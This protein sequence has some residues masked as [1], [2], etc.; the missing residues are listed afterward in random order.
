MMW[1][2]YI[3]NYITDST[4][5]KQKELNQLSQHASW[6]SAWASN[7]LLDQPHEP[8]SDRN[9]ILDYM[10]AWGQELSVRSA[11]SAPQWYEPYI[12]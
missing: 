6:L 1:F 4:E 12:G 11:T 5:S 9:L 3:V 7:C 8:Y 10:V 2:Y